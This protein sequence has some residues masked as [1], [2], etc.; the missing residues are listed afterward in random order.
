[1]ITNYYIAYLLFLKLLHPP[2]SPYS[3]ITTSFS[4]LSL[5][6]V[7]GMLPL[8]SR[9]VEVLELSMVSNK[10]VAKYSCVADW[11]IAQSI[12]IAML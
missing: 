9:E 3:I 6:Q 1:M 12:Q 4:Y 2:N 10:R 8:T 7:E 11:T 5:W